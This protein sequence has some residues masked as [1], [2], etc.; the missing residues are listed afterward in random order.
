MGTTDAAAVPTGRRARNRLVRSRRY[1]RAALH[2]ATDEGLDALTM[3]RLADSVDAAVGTVYSYF[4]SKG[5]LV[6]EVQREAID[7]LA[8]SALLLRTDS[9]RLAADQ[10]LT[11]ADLAAFRLIAFGRWFCASAVTFPE[12]IRL[13]QSLMGEWRSH[14]PMDEV[15]RVLPAAMALLDQARACIDAAEQHGAVTPGDSMAR[16]VT[17][18][19]AVGGVLQVSK[20]DEIDAEL[21]D[22]VTLAE[23]LCVDLLRGWGVSEERLDR[24]NE[25]LDTLAG[26]GRLAPPVPD[27][28]EPPTP[29]TEATA[30]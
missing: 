17:L 6:A 30:P 15:H 4:P 13:M 16:V 20:L 9:D 24:S 12:E 3:Q 14:V 1:L 26:D 25:L 2:I 27:A 11:G 28:D 10:G 22:G 5:A 29:S 23:Q 21:F 19:A 18:A 8:T 7:R